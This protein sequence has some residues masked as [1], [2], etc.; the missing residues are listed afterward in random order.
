MNQ[1]YTGSAE[2]LLWEEKEPA[3]SSDPW[4]NPIFHLSAILSYPLGQPA[5]R[6][7]GTTE[8]AHGCDTRDLCQLRIAFGLCCLPPIL[9][10]SAYFLSL[11]L[12]SAAEAVWD[13]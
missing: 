12:F 13:L 7:S 1:Q 2:A 8:P 3:P 6:N 9:D 11:S 4:P 5:Q 10:L